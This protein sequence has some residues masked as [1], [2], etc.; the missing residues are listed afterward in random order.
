MRTTFPLSCGLWLG[1]RG[2]QPEMHYLHHRSDVAVGPQG[3]FKC[4]GRAGGSGRMESGGRRANNATIGVS[5]ALKVLVGD[6][7]DGAV[8]LNRPRDAFGL[9]MVLVACL[10]IIKKWLPNRAVLTIGLV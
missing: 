4:D 6:V 5:A 7:G 9:A 3:P 8:T 2:S 10:L 1:E